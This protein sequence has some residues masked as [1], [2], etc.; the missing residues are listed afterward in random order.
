MQEGIPSTE[1]IGQQ[2]RCSENTSVEIIETYVTPKEQL[3][4][5][6]TPDSRK[7]NKVDAQ[8]MPDDLAGIVAVWPRLPEYIKR[9]IKALIEAGRDS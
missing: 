3:T 7:E 1:V 4:P 9:A 6:L 2:G 5:Q 8:N